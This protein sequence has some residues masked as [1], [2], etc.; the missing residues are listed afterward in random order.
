MIVEYRVLQEN[1]ATFDVQLRKN[2]EET[3]RDEGCLRM[4]IL[5]HA[6]KAGQVVLHELWANETRIEKHQ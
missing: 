5:R 1:Q 6:T 3:L 2:V 4:E